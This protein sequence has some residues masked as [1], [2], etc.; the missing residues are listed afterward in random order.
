MKGRRLS[1]RIR[2][3]LGDR[4]IKRKKSGV[5]RKESEDKMYTIQTVL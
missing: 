4:R 3:E 1:W 2:K 5:G